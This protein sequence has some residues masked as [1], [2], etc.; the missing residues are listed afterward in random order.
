MAC[1]RSTMTSRMNASMR[2]LR[3]FRSSSVI[4]AG[5][6]RLGLLRASAPP[7]FVRLSVELKD[8]S[9]VVVPN[10]MIRP[11]ANGCRNGWLP[12]ASVSELV[13][14]TGQ[15]HNQQCASVNKFVASFPYVLKML[16]Y[17]APACIIGEIGGTS[18]GA[19]AAHATHQM[20][21]ASASSAFLTSHPSC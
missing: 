12:G 16:H 19:F 17:A 5:A 15:A 7:L 18:S 6:T 2:P 20:A 8:R 14:P 11:P 13:L 9:S 21:A 3:R 1:P 10:A 4:G